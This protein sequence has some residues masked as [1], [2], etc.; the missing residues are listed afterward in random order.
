MVPLRVT[1]PVPG[2]KVPEFDQVPATEKLPVFEAVRLAAGLMVMF[3][4]TLT[5]G[6]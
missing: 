1:V 3:P 2:V 4:E 6:L 5:V